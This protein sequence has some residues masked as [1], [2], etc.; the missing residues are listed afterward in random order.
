MGMNSSVGNKGK[1]QKK[2]NIGSYKWLKELGVDKNWKQWIKYMT[3]IFHK[4]VY[5]KYA[6]HKVSF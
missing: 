2:G 1:K 3:K 5:K 6:E 4:P